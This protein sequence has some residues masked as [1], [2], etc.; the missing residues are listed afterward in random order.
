[1]RETVTGRGLIEPNPTGAVDPNE[2]R[3]V[4]IGGEH[5]QGIRQN[6]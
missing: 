4:P 1:M 3:G 2:S 5:M 6:N